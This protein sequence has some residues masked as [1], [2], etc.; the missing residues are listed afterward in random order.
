[1]NRELQIKLNRIRDFLEQN[2]YDAMLLSNNE[3]FSWL[4]CGH[5]AFVDKS[6]PTA[7]AQL[8]ITPNKQYVITN[9]SEQFRIPQE[10]L[11]G[12]EFEQITYN[13]YKNEKE[14]L[15]PFLNNK[16]ITS[17]N[18]MMGTVNCYNEIASLRFQLTDFEVD[19]YREIGTIC[20][21]IVER[22][23]YEIEPGQNENEIAGK[24]TGRLM[25][26]GF[27]VP[28]CL[29][30]ADDRLLKYRH[31]I[32]TTAIVENT[33]M[34]A[35]CAQKYG[36]TI[37]M[38]RIVSFV[39]LNDETQKK[40][41]A[42]TNIDATCILSTIAGAKT[43]DIVRQIHDAYRDS[44]YEKEFH[45]HHQGGATGYLTRDYC[46]NEDYETIVL[47]HQAFSWNPT[48]SGVK[49]EDT[50]I[51][52]GNRQEILSLTET[53]PSIEV[54]INDTIIRRPDILIK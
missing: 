54:K 31:P 29:V 3:N 20:S 26:A 27:Q 44:G 7:V 13:W 34:I 41:T 45:F 14:V 24:V 30:A 39:P 21:K 25:G 50:F 1:M 16:N 42:V 11:M 12:L 17:D 35:V 23:C 8:L 18:G 33:A 53:W 48:I 22:C 28:V 49:V 9:S 36:L 5:N 15:G 38:S 19:R 40:Y 37:S 43:G 32:P 47:D 2:S 4:S 52:M 10:E 46:A 6:S 51:V